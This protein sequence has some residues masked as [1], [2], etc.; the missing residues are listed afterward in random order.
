MC[1]R[2]TLTAET[3]T[4]KFHFG[5][6]TQNV[7]HSPRYNIAPGQDIP[8]IVNTSH[9]RTFTLMRWGLIPSWAKD[10][11]ISYKMIN[12]RAET[13]EQRPAF[14]ESFFRRRC[15]IP[16]DGFYEWKKQNGKKLPMRIVLT[17]SRL[18]AFAGIWDSWTSPEG[19]SIFSCS[20][21]TT[22]ANDCIKDIHDR[23]PV[24]LAGEEEYKLWLEQSNP[25]LLKELLKP[26]Q[27]EMITYP[28]SPQVNSP[29]V[30]NPGCIKRVNNEL[31]LF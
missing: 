3:E 16:T 9:K 21:I 7:N 24:I 14:R 5:I 19:S 22:K 30:D 28:V 23:M 25:A 10:K 8:V 27:G 29:K 1:G 2:F 12:A 6:K 18:Y 11:S 20:I 13:I 4:I 31:S 26:Y 17:D 15:I